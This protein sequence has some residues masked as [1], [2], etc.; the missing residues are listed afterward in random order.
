MPQVGSAEVL[1]MSVR[2]DPPN[3][4]QRTATF[5]KPLSREL[6]FI[7]CAFSGNGS[8]Q[9]T[10]PEGPTIRAANT[11]KKPAL[12]R[13][14]CPTPC[15]ITASWVFTIDAPQEQIRRKVRLRCWFCDRNRNT[16]GGT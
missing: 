5:V 9:I 11:P 2:L 13:R 6:Y 3:A 12:K 4:S 15:I 8:K 16:P 10:W 14:P 7:L 1:K